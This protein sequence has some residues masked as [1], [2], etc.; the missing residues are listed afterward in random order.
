MYIPKQFGLTNPDII[1][2]FIRENGFATLVSGGMEYPY[3]THIPIELEHN[4][5][6]EQILTGHLAKANPH[7]KSFE[8]HP[9]VTAIFLSDVNHYISSSWYD[10]PNA[11]TW[12]YISVHVSGRIKIL[13]KQ[14]TWDAVKRLTDRY[15][16]ISSKPVSLETLPP[17]IQ[18][19]ISGV[20]AFEIE[21]DHI[22]AVCKMSQN[23]D[24]KNYRLIL[25]E[26]RK[27][28]DPKALLLADMMEELRNSASV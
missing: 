1:A 3:A 23:R 20:I 27:L 12:N 28:A 13:D 5:K 2:R 10:H 21:I 11:P 16:S 6:G 19:E 8:S 22:D 26:L 4:A 7:W 15:E 18:S 24:D 25:Q 9:L 14:Q 17:A